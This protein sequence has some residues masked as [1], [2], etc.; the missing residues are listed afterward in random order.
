[1]RGD[2]FGVLY[3]HI[4]GRLAMHPLIGV[5]DHCHMYRNQ[6]FG[7]SK[8]I[9]LLLS[10]SVLHAVAPRRAVC[11]FPECQTKQ[12]KK[13]AWIC[14]HSRHQGGGRHEAS[15]AEGAAA[16]PARLPAATIWNWA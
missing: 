15:H 12:N 6:P 7:L 13:S 16:G 2:F 10:F 14:F 3:L 11:E 8:K 4:G 9:C 1:M 5:N